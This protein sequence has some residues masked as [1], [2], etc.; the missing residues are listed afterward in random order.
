MASRTS[1][2]KWVAFRD[3][4]SHFEYEG[5]ALRMAWPRLHRGD[6]EPFPT[7]KG[8]AA[9]LDAWR[10][11]HAGRFQAACQQGDALGAAGAAVAN[12]AAGVYATYLAKDEVGALRIL[13]AAIARGER[14]VAETPK[15]PNAHYLHAF[16]LGRYSQRI[17]VVRA[18][19]EGL[20]GK[21]QKSLERTLELEPKHAEAHVAYAVFQAEIIDKVGSL[22]G[23]ISYGAT[24]DGALKHFEQ[25][26]RLAPDS[27]VA[28]LEYARGLGLLSPRES[29]R[30][31]ELLVAAVSI[32]PA[33][34]M[35]SLDVDAAKAALTHG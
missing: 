32:E 18:L 24:R 20:G 9:L 11:F 5:A 28:R 27:P 34:A 29:A 12:K 31:K 3:P 7:G 14:A 26:I 10:D 25:A 23:R 30:A 16:A 33:D 22:A 13:E 17:S 1:G 35:E 15:N 4:K 21:V 6:A 19:A 8:A 2:A